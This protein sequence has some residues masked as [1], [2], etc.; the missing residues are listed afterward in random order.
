MRDLI[1]IVFPKIKADWKHLAYSLKYDIPTVKEI[2]RDSR[3]SRHC[4][5]NLF[6]D[7]LSTPHGASPKTWHTLL[8]KIKE[9]DSLSAAADYIKR[10]PTRYTIVFFKK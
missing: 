6:I 3:D 2:E 1:T 7:W 9:V 5:I 10:E 8:Q 4:C